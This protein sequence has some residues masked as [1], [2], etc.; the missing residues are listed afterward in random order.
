VKLSVKSTTLNSS[1]KDVPEGGTIKEINKNDT[2]FNTEYFNNPIIV[3]IMNF[4]RDPRSKKTNLAIYYSLLAS[5]IEIRNNRIIFN[6]SENE[7][8]EYEIL[9]KYIDEL[10][11][12]ISLLINESYEVSLLFSGKENETFNLS[13]KAPTYQEKRLF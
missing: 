1:F 4:F 5:K 13:E 11:V 10:K 3:K 12:N 6:F 8:L 9:K 2:D 7:L